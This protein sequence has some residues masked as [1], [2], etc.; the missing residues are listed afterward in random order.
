VRIGRMTEKTAIAQA[1]AVFFHGLR[2][3]SRLPA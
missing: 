3:K 2:E 1:I